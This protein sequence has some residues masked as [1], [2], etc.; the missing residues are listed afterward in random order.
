MPRS[1]DKRSPVTA[2]TLVRAVKGMNDVLPGEIGRWHRVEAAFR[3]SMERLGYRE[4]R[5]PYV[6]PT[7]LFVRAIGEATDVVEKEMYSFVFHDEPLTLRPEGTAGAAR[8]YVEHKVHNDEP[9]SR[10]YY[11]GPMFRGERPAKGR[12]RQFYQLGAECFG[13]PGPGCDA[14]MIDALVGFLVDIGVPKPDVFVNSIGSAETRAKYKQA[15]VDVLT[16]Q[17]E[18]LSADSQRRLLTNPLRILDSKHPADKAAIESAPTILDFLSDEDRVHWDGL[19]RH[20]DALGTPYTVDPKLVRGLDYYGRTLFEIKGAYEKLGAGSTLLGGGRY[21][22]M[23]TELGGPD[24]PAIGF[25]AG[26]E[27]LLIASDV[28][29]PE[30]VVDVLIAPIGDRAA[31]AA[32]VLGRDV[33]KAGVR[34]E[35][36]TR[37]ASI[38]SQLRRANALG[39]RFAVILGDRE[40][41]E[42]IV[43]LKDLEAHSQEKVAKSALPTR[44][45]ALL[46]VAI[47]VAVMGLVVCWPSNAFAQLGGGGG[48]KQGGP[49]QTSPTRNKSVGPQRGGSP[50]EDQQGASPASRPLDE[51]TAIA[52]SDP[53][54]IPEGVGDRIG[55]D[56]DG[57]P[58]SAEGSL[59]RSFFPYY[60]ERR[61]DYRLRLLPPLYLE[62]TRGLDP[63]TGESTPQTDRESLT[64][65]LFYQRRSPSWDADVLFP[66]AWRVRDRDNHVLVLGPLVHREAPNEHD[67]WIAPILFQGHRKDGGYFHSP[68]TLTSSHWDEKGAFT[69]VGPYFRDRTLKDVDA[70]VAPFWF[71]GDNGDE[72][73][74]RKT[75]TLIPPLL[76]FHRERE[77]D[78]S[79]LTVVGPVITKSDPKRSVFDVAPLLFTI[80]GKPETGGV[81]EFHYTLFPLFHYGRDPD[82]SLFVLPGYLRRVTRTADTLVTPFYTH[83]TTRNDSTSLTVVGPI[84][85][86]YYRATDIDIGYSAL[87]IFPFFYNSSSPTGRTFATPLFARS[88]NYNVSRTNWIFPTIVLQN[89]TKGWEVDVHPIVYLGRNERSTHTVLA[90]ILWDFASPKGRTTV[91]FP[92]Y[93]RF[94]DS[95]DGS[96]IQVAANTLYKEK[97]VPGGSD[98]QFHLLP[99]FSYGQSPSGSWAN[100]LFGLL[101]Y[102]HDGPTTK[103]K[104]FWLPI[105]VAGGG[106]AAVQG[107]PPPPASS[108][109][110]PAPAPESPAPA[111]PESA[112]PRSNF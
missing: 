96:V 3:S 45:A 12:Y 5:T 48:G 15:L 67:N 16:P 88:E 36:D 42:G 20:L 33:R 95:T 52:P 34:C 111:T 40:I 49:T 57:R 27:R 6:E 10:W 32:L 50:D 100:I 68:L 56:Y 71:H 29:V 65:L 112:P 2:P 85:P 13:D 58:P 89:D 70:G 91:G 94:A 61:G 35:V 18:T 74:A 55:S 21:D 109:P 31:D 72:D 25:A 103:I 7:P 30:S 76:Y 51:P 19:R 86:I 73:G 92:L 69:I 66:L 62:H 102:D 38:K 106:S 87:G 46:A 8:A 82:K 64:A 107:P 63:K 99:I 54:A 1:R 104:T 84:V 108:T 78:E 90:P 105:T 79:Q 11:L 22:G 101:G 60:E 98:W 77:I 28:A 4:V 59:H 14:E 41:D 75:Y 93:W 44:L 110:S 37:K 83:A 53:L 80:N 9:V 17:K 39:A 47:A 81:H 97:R 26:L 24:V 43:E 23:I